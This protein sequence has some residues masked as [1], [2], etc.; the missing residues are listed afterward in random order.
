[1][2]DCDLIYGKVEHLG[3]G[4]MVLGQLMCFRWR[5]EILSGPIALGALLSAIAV[6][7]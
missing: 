4:L 3:D 7:I 2:R 1:M 6:L 5:G